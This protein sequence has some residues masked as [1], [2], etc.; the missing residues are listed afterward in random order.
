[1]AQ[2]FKGH[3]VDDG[4][5][6]M[7]QRSSGAGVDGGAAGPAPSTDIDLRKLAAAAG[8]L[9]RITQLVSSLR[10]AAEGM[11]AALHS[12]AQQ[13]G[14][15]EGLARAQAEVQST[16][17]EAMSALTAA[18]SERLAIAEQHEAALADLA[19]RIARKVIGAH[20]KADPELVTAIVTETIAELEPKVSLE[21]RVNPGDVAF[22]EAAQTELERLVT[23]PGSVHV[24]SD[25]TVAHGGCVLV[26]PVGEV[27]ARIETKLSVLQTA[28]TAQRRQLVDG[29]S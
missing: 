26:S 22:V 11:S 7:P 9:E 1:M 29:G 5:Y 27:D 2:L 10:P 3:V 6:P 19:M 13:Q 17:L 21:V 25:N 12:T 4:S 18:Q 23:G 16:M 20:L 14:Y 24:V 8:D 15:S 28:F